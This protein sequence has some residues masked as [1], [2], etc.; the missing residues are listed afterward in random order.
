MLH[1]VECNI[2]VNDIYFNRRWKS[3]HIVLESLLVSTSGEKSVGGKSRTGTL[4]KT[5]LKWHKVKSI[6]VTIRE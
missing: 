3:L 1:L 2:N 4:N 5:R 6:A